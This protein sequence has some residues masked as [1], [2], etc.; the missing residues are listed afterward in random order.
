[1]TSTGSLCSLHQIAGHVSGNF[2]TTEEVTA[3]IPGLRRVK[4]SGM[5]LWC[6]VAH[7][8]KRGQ[9]NDSSNDAKFLGHQ[10]PSSTVE[11]VESSSEV[12]LTALLPGLGGPGLPTARRV[13]R[14]PSASKEITS[15]R[16]CRT[17]RRQAARSGPSFGIVRAACSVRRDA[18]GNAPKPDLMIGCAR[19]PRSTIAIDTDIVSRVGSP[20]PQGT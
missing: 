6:R 12:R 14:P 8:T 2:V 3:M 19:V 7:T 20:L 16:S 10:S 13:R 4:C 15:D 1:M 9:A 5:R 17:V 11:N 18:Y